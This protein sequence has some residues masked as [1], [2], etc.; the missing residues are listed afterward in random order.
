MVKQD[1]CCVGDYQI[2]IPY[3]DFEKMVQSAYKIEHIEKVCATME[4]KYVAMQE[5]YREALQKIAEINSLL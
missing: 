3:R 5:L 2:I 1:F 4:Q